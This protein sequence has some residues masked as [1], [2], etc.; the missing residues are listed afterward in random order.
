MENRKPSRS[1]F[2][3]VRK[4]GA[5]LL[6]IGYFP[7]APGTIGAAFGAAGI[8]YVHARWGDF[9][10]PERL[11]LYWGALFLLVML[12]IILTSKGKE[13]FGVD[14]PPQVIFDEVVGQA[15]T[16]FMVPIT[17]PTLIVG[18]LL[19]RFFD[20]VKPFPIHSMQELE[21]G[22]GVTMDDVIAGVFANIT[23]M[24][25]LAGYHWV[26]AYL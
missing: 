9:L 7:F 18:F 20:I 19:F 13:T 5:S 3:W 1:L 21:G 4:A 17:L 22:V 10:T 16:F 26:R 2:Y 6:F 23:L 24:L 15:V 8:W 14:D 25:I 12:S 11:V